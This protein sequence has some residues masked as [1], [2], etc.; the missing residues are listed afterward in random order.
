MTNYMVMLCVLSIPCHYERFCHY[1]RS[2]VI[3]TN[4]IASVLHRERSVATSFRNENA[5]CHREHC[6]AISLQGTLEKR[7]KSQST[8]EYP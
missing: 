1:E 8:S 2:A 6:E 5:T 3:S 4:E 7:N